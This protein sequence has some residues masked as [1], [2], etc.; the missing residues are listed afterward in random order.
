MCPPTPRV[1]GAPPIPGAALRLRLAARLGPVAGTQPTRLS[2]GRSATA[3]RF[4]RGPD[5]VVVKMSPIPRASGPWTT[6]RDRAAARGARPVPAIAP[7][8]T[9]R[10]GS[11]PD[12]TGSGGA[13]FPVDPLLEIHVMTMLARRG[14][15]ALPTMAIRHGPDLCLAYPFQAGRTGQPPGPAL[16]RLLRRLHRLPP[17]ALPHLPRPPNGRGILLIRAMERL[18]QEPDGPAL[19]TRVITATAAARATP[20]GGMVP[21]HGDPV[22]GNV[23][24]GPR[25]ARLIDWH[26]V[27][28]GDACHDLALALSPAMQ[29]IHGL[30]PCTAAKRDIFLAAY[31]DQATTARFMATVAW[32]HG[33]MIG[34][35]LW[36]LARGDCAYG[37]A[38]TA[39]IAALRALPAP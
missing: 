12:R 29:V 9:N 4:G 39:E 5:A 37:P 2:G 8:P 35:C 31:G 23:V 28:R 20:P 36:R 21:L 34:H 10:G 25:G 22:P 6:S 7:A 32:H 13:L 14:L 1:F 30:S 18:A 33:L 15:A 27:H 19:G 38:L 17:T 16:A 26:S 3:F 24:H 11:A